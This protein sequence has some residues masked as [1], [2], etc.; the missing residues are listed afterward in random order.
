MPKDIDGNIAFRRRLLEVAA[1]DDEAARVLWQLC[2]RDLLFFVNAFCWIYEPRTP[3]VL[4]YVTYPIQDEFLSAV[5]QAA[6]QSDVGADKSRDMG[7]SWGVLTWMLWRWN[8]HRLQSF[9]CVSRTEDLVDGDSDSLFWKLDFLVKH[10]PWFLRPTLNGR[11]RTHLYLEHPDTGSLINGVSTTG[12][13]ARGGR[14]TAIL[15]DEFHAFSYDDGYKVLASTQAVTRTRIFVSTPQGPSGAF[16]DMMHEPGLAIR[17]LRLHWSDHPDKRRGLYYSEQGRVKIIDADYVFPEG[18]EFVLDG[19]LRSPWY[20]YECKRCPVPSLIAQELDCDY[21]GSVNLAFNREIINVCLHR[22]ARPPLL[23]AT[24][25]YVYDAAE[26][27]RL[28]VD[29][30]GPIRLWIHVDAYTRLPAD[31]HYVMG[32]DVSRGTL[33]KRGQSSSN[34]VAMLYN[35]ATGVKV[36]SLTRAGIDPKEFAKEVVAWARW[37]QGADEVGPLLV[38]E[39]NGPGREFGDEVVR[40]NYRHIYYRR[41][42][43]ETTGPLAGRETEVPGW[44][45]TKENKVAMLSEYQRALAAGE[46]VNREEAALLECEQYVKLP[47][48]CWEHV[49]SLGKMDPD[50]AGP[51]HGDRVIADGLGWLG[52]HRRRPGND[53]PPTETPRGSFAERREERRREER[54]EKEW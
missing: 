7:V 43:N 32:I 47:N 14:R 51:S 13:L 44:W 23:R 50:I 27:V 10:L 1:R 18:Y 36:G 6:G 42:K 49:H 3:A 30:N 48:G 31:Q 40:L 41:A 54:R 2:R 22:D 38:W 46:C 11:Q 21:V 19:K 53:E 17:R 45:S 35:R 4:P 39:A 20:D 5:D 37:I 33:N 15:L 12:N 29:E 34:S 24:L 16:Y 25:E 8:F 28:T 52:C 9:L 26:P